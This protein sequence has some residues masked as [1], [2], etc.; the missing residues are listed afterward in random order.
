MKT[1]LLTAAFALSF[2]ACSNNAPVGNGNSA[3]G[4][5][6]VTKDDALLYAADADRDSV[7]VVDATTDS[8]LAEIKVGRQPEKV[9]VTNDDVIYVTNRLDRSISVIRRGDTVEA[10]RIAVG[11]EP[12]SMAITSD[13]KTLYVVNAASLDETEYGTLMAVDTK[14]QQVL[15]ELPVGHEPRGLALTAN[16]TKAVIS[17]YKDGDV[18]TV[19]LTKRSVVSANSGLYAQLNRSALGL[20]DTGGTSGDVVPREPALGAQTAHAVGMEALLP[21]LDGLQVYGTSLLSSDQTLQTRSPTEIDPLS[22]DKGTVG[23]NGSPQSG[24][25]GGNCGA[26]AV[27][28]PALLTFDDQGQ[29]QVDDVTQCF[30]ASNSDR[31]PMML[32][33]N[34]PGM[35]VQGP[36]A[37]ALDP[38]G[39]FLFIANR[40]SNNV[41]I[42]PTTVRT[43]LPGSSTVAVDA[44]FGGFDTSSVVGTVQQLI[45]VGASPTGVAVSHD[46][47]RAWAFNAFDHSISR[48]EAVNG[49]VSN[50]ATTQLGD[51]VLPTDV[52]VGR[53]LFFSAVDARMNNPGTGI[54]CGTCHLEGREDG[55][56]WNTMEGPRQTPSLAGRMTEKTA[57]FH[58]NGEFPD[59]MAFMSHTVTRRMGGAGVTPVMEKQVAAFIGSIPAPDN[60]LKDRTSADTVTR[61]RQVFDKAECATCHTGETMTD[62][63]FA[64]VGTMVSTGTVVDRPEFNAKGLNTPS[65][66]GLGRSAPYLHDG[67]AVTLRARI[68]QNKAGNQH[69]KTADLSDSEV[70]DLVA[71]LKTL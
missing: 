9:L 53:K 30:G 10:S 22:S 49:T 59:L 42:I 4:S 35:P 33:S 2:A 61:G 71:Y 52:V 46:G 41:A 13:G 51:D 47:K 58:W 37:I 20:V 12:V 55:H 6:A 60:A 43:S 11:V 69:G 29:P 54:S 70:S 62:N 18:V 1:R 67:S 40:E 28:S 23:L 21:S 15:W 17:L 64:F 8:R 25:S 65:L 3:N 24:Y 31:P 63:K 26:A 16:G 34:I 14:S 7:F 39:T 45:N 50:V 48:L 36:S 19:D 57:P 5:I 38:T 56:V 32:T 66:L 44:K 27:A 68:M